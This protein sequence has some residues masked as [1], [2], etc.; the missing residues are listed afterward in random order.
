MINHENKLFE[1]EDKYFN[2]IVTSLIDVCELFQVQ[3]L[4]KIW[5]E[6]ERDV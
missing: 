1:E 6:Y 3:Y 5:N 4:V 2:F